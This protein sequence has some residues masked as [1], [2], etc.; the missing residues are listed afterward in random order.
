MRRRSSSSWRRSC[1]LS[2]PNPILCS[3]R[4]QQRRKGNGRGGGVPVPGED[5]VPQSQVF[6]ILYF[7]PE[8]DAREEEEMDEEEEFQ[9]QEKIMFPSR[10]CS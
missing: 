6:L 10:K 8:E 1:P 2:V 3:R 5:H 4:R 7:V 9:F